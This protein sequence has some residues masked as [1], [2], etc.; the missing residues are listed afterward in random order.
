MKTLLL[1]RHAKSDWDDPSLGDFDRP[2]ADRGERDAPEIGKAL[3]KRSP[4]PD[5]VIGSPAARA[6]ATAKA[7]VKAAKIKLEIQ[8]EEA[9]YGAS[10]AEL[11]NLIRRLPDNSSCAMLVGH[12][13]GFEDLLG[14][15]SGSHE[16]MPTAALAC[17]E[18]QATN[19]SEVGE[20]EGKLVWLLTPKQLKAKK[21]D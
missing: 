19:W 6:K 5:L 4:L 17:L 13:P 9:I 14:R 15:L 2:L 12:N 1:L 11:V 21:D 20:N 18:F 8:Y 3:R 16:R 10:S 7:V